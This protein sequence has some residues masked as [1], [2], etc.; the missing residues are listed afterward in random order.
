MVLLRVAILLQIIQAFV[1][2]K[3]RDFT[4]WA[5]YC[6]IAT[7]VTYWGCATLLEIFSCNPREKLW[8]FTIPGKC[9]DR[10]VYLISGCVVNI[11]S[12]V[13]IMVLP[14]RVT[15]S[16]RLT[17][18]QKLTLAPL[19]MIG[20]LLVTCSAL[21]S[22]YWILLTSNPGQSCSL[23]FASTKPFTAGPRTT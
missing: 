15:W 20:I 6:I 23:L 17:R 12:D 4:F 19:F 11:V 18:K 7:N 2:K 3:T 14:Q 9:T 1:P 16:L 10:H 22:K 8:N 13:T 21:D 5:A